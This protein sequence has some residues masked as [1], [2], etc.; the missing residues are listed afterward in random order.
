MTMEILDG[1]RDFSGGYK[2]GRKQGPAGVPRV[3]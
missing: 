3:V 2:G 1:R